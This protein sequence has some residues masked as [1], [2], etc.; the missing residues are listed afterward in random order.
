VFFYTRRLI[1]LFDSVCLLLTFLA[2]LLKKLLVALAVSSAVVIGP[3]SVL[4][5]TMES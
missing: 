5:L 2:A 4:I 3:V 1:A